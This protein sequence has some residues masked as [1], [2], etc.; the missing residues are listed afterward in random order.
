M[1]M[2]ASKQSKQQTAV[3]L[4]EQYDTG[5]WGGGYESVPA[6]YRRSDNPS[7]GNS[8]YSQSS[9]GGYG[10]SGQGAYPGSSYGGYPRGS[11]GGNSGPAV[12]HASGHGARPGNSSWAAARGK[13]DQKYGATGG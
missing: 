1:M 5:E 3:P 9:S 11:Y 7:Y 8:S 4:V 6:G 13:I 2:A 10:S 12:S